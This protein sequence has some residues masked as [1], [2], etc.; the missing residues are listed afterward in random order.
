MKVVIPSAG[1]GTRLRPHT[2]TVPKSLIYVAGKPILGHILDRLI[3]YK[4]E[5]VVI[6]V[7][8]MGDAIVE[9][10]KKR[11][12]FKFEFVKQE[13]QHGLGHAVYQAKAAAGS[14]E[15][16][17]ILGDTIIDWQMATSFRKECF[18]GVKKVDEPK[19]YG[20]VEIE[21][22]YIKCVVEK[23]D[24]PPSD[25]A[26]VGIYYITDFKLLV[27]AIDHLIEK[28]ILTRGEYQLSDALQVMVKRGI[29]IRAVKV[30]EW[31]DCGNA[32]S[33]IEA[34]RYLLNKNHYYSKREGSI[35]IPPCY[36]DDS[37]DL[38]ESI[39]GPYVSVGAE[40]FIGCSIMKD[41]IVNPYAQVKNMLVTNS[42]IGEKAIV[43]GTYKRLNVGDSSEMVTT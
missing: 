29:S 19:R 40:A 4:P 20:I 16:L 39:V 25:Q 1:T 38:K 23:P 3:P 7:G 26:I 41:A 28:K 13:E 10:V 36:I 37:A 6:V 17:I 33:L 5:L 35:I 42:I 30:D 43:K 31:Y 27:S 12:S 14:G 11:Y 15:T 9:Y 24:K 34:N 22:E 2:Y 21:D 32:N 18:I 8:Y